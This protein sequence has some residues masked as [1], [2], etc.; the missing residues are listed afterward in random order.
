M[1]EIAN[2]QYKS[3]LTGLSFGLIAD[4]CTEVAILLGLFLYSP[5]TRLWPC[6]LVVLSLYLFI[7]IALSTHKI[8]GKLESTASTPAITF[9]EQIEIFLFFLGMILFPQHF[10]VL[11]IIFSLCLWVF[12]IE[13]L[14]LLWRYRNQ[15][16]MTKSKTRSGLLC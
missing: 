3:S 5:A 2:A 12:L 10:L 16:K 9:T 1:G 11:A 7:T 6:I 15:A 4:R 13:R 14:Q 8:L